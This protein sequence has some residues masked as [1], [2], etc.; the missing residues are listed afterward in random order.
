MA[1]IFNLIYILYVSAFSIKFRSQIIESQ[2]SNYSYAPVSLLFDHIRL[3]MIAHN[4]NKVLKYN[5][6]SWYRII[7]LKQNHF[8][9]DS[10]LILQHEIF[11]ILMK[12]FKIIDKR[13]NVYFLK[14]WD[15]YLHLFT[16]KN[17]LECR[18][19]QPTWICVY[20]TVLM[21]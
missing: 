2:V 13:V 20:F 10:A 12:Q 3:P 21:K 8:K 7:H 18:L 15:Y 4:T 19:G 14:V 17:T 5:F 11:R 9:Y 6:Y 1:E 16:V